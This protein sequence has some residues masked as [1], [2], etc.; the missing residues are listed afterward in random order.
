MAPQL[1]EPARLNT[2]TAYLDNRVYL[3]GSDPEVSRYLPD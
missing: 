3:S 1:G 2:G